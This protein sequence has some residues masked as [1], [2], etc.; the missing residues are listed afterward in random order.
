MTK[1]RVIKVGSRVTVRLKDGRSYGSTSYAT[2]KVVEVKDTIRG[3]WFAVKGKDIPKGQT[4]ARAC[5][6]A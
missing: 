6:L 3:P 4:K 1:K 5:Q 2:G